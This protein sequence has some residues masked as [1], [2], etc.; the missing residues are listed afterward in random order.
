MRRLIVIVGLVSVLGL[1]GIS[2]STRVHDLQQALD[3]PLYEGAEIHWEARLA[4]SEMPKQ[5]TEW[6]QALSVLQ[7]TSYQIEGER[8]IEVLSFYEQALKEWRRILWTKP[9]ES[10][11]VQLWAQ[12]GSYLYIGTAKRAEATE[13][14]IITA[15]TDEAALDVP[16]FEGAQPQ[17]EVFFT[18]QDLLEHLKRWFAN[19]LQNLPFSRSPF[20]TEPHQWTNLLTWLTQL[21]SDM[22]FRLLEDLSE[23]RVVGYKLPGNTVLDLLS[24]YEQHFRDWR[25]NFWMKPDATWGMRVFTRSDE[26]GLRELVLLLSW[27]SYGLGLHSWGEE[28]EEHPPE[29][30]E[31]FV[32]RGRR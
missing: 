20:L 14:L 19:L 22:A 7:A 32:L 27:Q 24:F 16:I 18:R 25:R 12:E 29:I 8:A 10:G 1:G 15:Q 23:L 30:T 17:W 2:A 21:G 3:I 31:V 26:A 4:P 11:G 5:I 13:L 28:K 6:A 9:E